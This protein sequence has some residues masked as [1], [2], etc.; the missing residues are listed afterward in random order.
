[1]APSYGTLQV[2]IDLYHRYEADYVVAEANNGGDIVRTLLRAIDPHM[3]VR[4]VHATRG[5]TD[6]V[7]PTPS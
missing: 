6:D 7:T 1:M 5:V 2:V 4:M 3:P